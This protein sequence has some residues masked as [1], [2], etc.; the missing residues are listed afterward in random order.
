MKIKKNI[1]M[2]GISS[3]FVIGVLSI[4]LNKPNLEENKRYNKNDLIISSNKP[5]END[6]NKTINTLYTQASFKKQYTLT[7]LIS[8]AEVIALGKV[9]DLEGY[10]NKDGFFNGNIFSKFSFEVDNIFKGSINSPAIQV[11]SQGGKMAHYDFFIENSEYIRN[12]MSIDDFEAET[13]RLLKTRKTEEIEEVFE[14]TPNIYNNDIILLFLSY[15]EEHDNYYIASTSRFGKFNYDTNNKEFYRIIDKSDNNTRQYG[16][17]EV[18]SLDA[19]ENL[20]N[21]LPDNS[22]NLKQKQSEFNNEKSYKDN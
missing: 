8:D 18:I 2:Y 10:V 4:S 6:F 14:G 13:T 21:E 5:S 16:K 22:L 19:F 12:K 15:D 3:L 7:D 1:Y 20:V 11:V 17:E 9:K